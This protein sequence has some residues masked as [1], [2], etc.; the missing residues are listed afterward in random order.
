[1]AFWCLKT[2]LKDRILQE[3]ALQF[4]TVITQVHMNSYW[5]DQISNFKWK[6]PSLSQ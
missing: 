4:Y 3:Q 1:M 6:L 2:T 5:T